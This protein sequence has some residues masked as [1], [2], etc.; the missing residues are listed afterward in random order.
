MSLGKRIKALRDEKQ[1][2]QTA[3][4]RKAGVSQPVI[5]DYENDYVTQHR[6]HILLKVARA[7]ETTPDYLITGRGEIQLKDAP[8]NTQKLMDTYNLLT[9]DAQ[10][11]L[12]AI[13]VTMEKRET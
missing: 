7:L 9:D 6:M 2:S 11:M 10:A 3:L 5:S 1:M 4:A 8:I 12:L 13:A